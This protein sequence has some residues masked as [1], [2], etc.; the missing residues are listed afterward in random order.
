VVIDI[1]TFLQTTLMLFIILDPL[2]NA[3]IFYSLTMM[4]SEK[5]R[6][7]IIRMSVIVAALILLIFS[8]G[9]VLILNFFNITVDDFR[10]AGGTIL[11]IIA[12]KGILGRV[13]AE[14]VERE[15]VAIVPMATPLLAGPGSI[16]TVIY[17]AQ[18]YG[19]YY[20]IISIIINA[21]LAYIL[22]INGDKLLAIL[23]RNGSIALA[24]IMAMILAAIAVSMVREGTIHIVER[25]RE[26]G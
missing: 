16:T 15:T 21:T 20:S 26:L 1:Y 9:G 17:V 23:G 5:D 12:V 14:T 11:F 3:P 6:R 8:I 10:I 18:A 25:I 22:L 7:S 19:I 2:G 24:R 4:L 13:E